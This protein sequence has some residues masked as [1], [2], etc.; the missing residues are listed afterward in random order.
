[1]KK[2]FI[3]LGLLL[4]TGCATVGNEFSDADVASIQKGV[5]T[6]QSVLTTFGKPYSVTSDSDGNTIYT[7]TYAHTVAFGVPQ[8]KSLIVKINKDG[9]VDSYVVSKTQP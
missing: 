8:G 3:A 6:K 9:V 4:L 5:T 7:W 1:M 2:L